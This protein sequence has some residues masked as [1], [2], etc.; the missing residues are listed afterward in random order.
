M[1]RAGSIAA[2]L[3]ASAAHVLAAERLIVR[4]SECQ[5]GD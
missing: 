1:F 4:V 5:T 2:A 3:R